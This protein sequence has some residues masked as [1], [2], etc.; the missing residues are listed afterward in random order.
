[1]N[2]LLPQAV[3][4]VIDANGKPIAGAK[5]NTYAAGT[6]IRLATF[7]D[8][9]STLEQ[10]N[11][12]VADSAGWLV[13]WGGSD[14]YKLVITDA[15]D[16]EIWT[17]DN[18]TI[19]YGGNNG[20]I[21]VVETI[22]AL[23]ALTITY[24]IVVVLGY[25][26]KSDGG[27]GTFNYDANKTDN[28]DNG[29]V[30]TPSNSIG[31]GRYVRQEYGD[32]NV[33]FFGAK[34]D[35]TNDDIDAF[36]RAVAYAESAG[37]SNHKYSVKIPA[38]NFYLSDVVNMLGSVDLKTL[39]E[40]NAIITTDYDKAPEIIPIYGENDEQ[41]KFVIGTGD[42]S[43]LS[44]PSEPFTHLIRPR[45][46][47]GTYHDDDIIQNQLKGL[48]LVYTQPA[49]TEE[50]CP[51]YT[52]YLKLTVNPGNCGMTNAVMIAYLPAAMSKL[53]ISGWAPGDG[54][55][56]LPNML[57]DVT[58]DTWYHVFLITNKLGNVDIGFDTSLV[59]QNLLGVASYYP[60][61]RRLG[62][63]YC[64][65]IDGTIQIKQFSQLGDWFHWFNSVLTS[66]SYS[67][68]ESGTLILKGIPDGYPVRT[69]G[70]YWL[71]NSNAPLMGVC[72]T[73]CDDA[74]A[75]TVPCLIDIGLG[76]STVPQ[77]LTL[78]ADID[79][80]IKYVC[81]GSSGSSTLECLIASYEDLRGKE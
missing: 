71:S 10:T 34:G 60:Y 58:T 20:T 41:Q 64:T 81:T 45:R 39:M 67:A 5:V 75:I 22:D 18:V 50:G 35:G 43:G 57:G 76:V 19:G 15:D 32:V 25:Y 48:S 46:Y 21:M 14:A 59:A 17:L 73:F 70:S 2:G 13:L 51:A 9:T 78:M 69:I 53:L 66:K 52:D 65:T 30:I 44:C 26:A 36:R 4:Q 74:S 24:S 42:D 7:V 6:D 47:G 11:P 8:A 27:G 29:Y 56:G 79:S 80:K 33:R 28:D 40:P 54:A 38:G 16:N 3:W 23:R 49:E 55:N 1:M 12:I 63:I 31:N 72:P 62:S 61:Y 68:P 77:Q 37:G